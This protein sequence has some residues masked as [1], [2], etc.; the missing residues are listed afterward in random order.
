MLANY[1]IGPTGGTAWNLTLMSYD[2]K[3]DMGLNVDV[4]AVPDAE[5]LGNA[6]EAEF[7]ALLAAGRTS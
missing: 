1:P 3:L 5:V 6:I 7:T 2:G 4:G